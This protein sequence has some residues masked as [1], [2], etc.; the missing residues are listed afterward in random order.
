MG[1]FSRERRVRDVK[2]HEVVKRELWEGSL[3]SEE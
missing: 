3:G 1:R 2:E